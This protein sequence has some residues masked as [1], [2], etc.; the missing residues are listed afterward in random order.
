MLTPMPRAPLALHLACALPIA[1]LAAWFGLI[2]RLPFGEGRCSSCGVEGYVIAA[3]L[4]AAAWLAAL[5][6]GAAAARRRLTDGVAAPGRVTGA[7]LA[8][9]AVFVG[10]SLLWHPVFT[11]A[12]FAAM[13][14]SLLPLPAGAIWW[15]MAGIGLW[16]H[17]PR[18]SLA[19]RRSMDC[20]LAASWI[21][22]AVLL[23]AVFGWVWVDRVEWLVF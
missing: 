4:V 20:A 9:V 7:G 14:V 12:A 21:T 5:V 10:A 17:P 16:R 6:A 8:G 19:L 13:L 3:H 1:G 11:P 18:T 2:D 15:L 23:P 22:L